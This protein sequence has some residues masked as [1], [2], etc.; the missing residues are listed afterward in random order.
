MS[1]ISTFDIGE[2]GTKDKL[3]KLFLKVYRKTGFKNSAFTDINLL[4]FL[5]SDTNDIELE[6]KIHPFTFL[7]LKLSIATKFLTEVDLRDNLTDAT[8][9]S[10]VD[11]ENNVGVASGGKPVARLEMIAKAFRKEVEGNKKSSLRMNSMIEDKSLIP[12]VSNE[13]ITN[14]TLSNI[15]YEKNKDEII[16][17]LQSMVSQLEK[18]NVELKENIKRIKLDNS[19]VNLSHNDGDEDGKDKVINDLKTENEYYIEEID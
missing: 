11:D 16:E 6:F 12:K 19:R 10:E 18:Q 17:D 5:E 13:R 8:R 14:I 15:I 3:Y 7:K 1:L 2:N 4:N 9:L